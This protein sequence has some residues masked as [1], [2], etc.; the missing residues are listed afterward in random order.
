LGL[1]AHQPK[2]IQALYFPVWFI[3]AKFLG[4][5]RKKSNDTEVC[6]ISLRAEPVT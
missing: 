2:M 6:G 1:K 5:V 4:K 3:D